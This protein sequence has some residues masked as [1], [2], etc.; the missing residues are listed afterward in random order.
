M[1]FLSDLVGSNNKNN[2]N[3]NIPVERA[4]MVPDGNAVNMVI[5]MLGQGQN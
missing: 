4:L 1:R 3:E 2:D 5:K